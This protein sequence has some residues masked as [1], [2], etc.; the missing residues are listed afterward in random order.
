MAEMDIKEFRA[1]RKH[2]GYRTRSLGDNGTGDKTQ[3]WVEL[4]RADGH[5]FGAMMEHL[6]DD[7]IAHDKE[8]PA[9]P[10]GYELKDLPAFHE[11]PAEEE[12]PSEESS[13]K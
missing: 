2:P 11:P 12:P 6:V 9:P 3:H 13:E 7:V 8:H 4:M 10:T 1:S 5:S